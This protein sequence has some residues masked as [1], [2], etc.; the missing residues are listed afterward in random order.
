MTTLPSSTMLPL[1]L[2]STWSPSIVVGRVVG[3]T[4][5][6]GAV[7]RRSVTALSGCG[8]GSSSSARAGDC[9]INSRSARPRIAALNGV[10]GTVAHY[11]YT[12][13][14]TRPAPHP[15]TDLADTRPGMAHRPYLRGLRRRQLSTL[16]PRVARR[17]RSGGMGAE[18]RHADPHGRSAR[19]GG[20]RALSEGELLAGAGR[21]A[22]TARACIGL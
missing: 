20:H 18:G 1:T 12:N 16:L 11:T 7:G 5:T 6:A 13:A 21:R 19:Q 22:R 14:R 2:Y 10:S 9:A 4:L 8:H 3:S 17:R 15:H